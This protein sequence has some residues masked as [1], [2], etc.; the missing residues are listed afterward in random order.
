MFKKLMLRTVKK[1]DILIVNPSKSKVKVINILES[2]FDANWLIDYWKDIYNV[3]LPKSFKIVVCQFATNPNKNYNYPLLKICVKKPI[4]Q[5]QPNLAWKLL[6][7]EY[8]NRGKQQ[9][10]TEFFSIY[11]EFL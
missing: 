9:T 10:K 7:Q 3:E 5:N 11:E 4:R 8:N 6:R 2:T 1:D